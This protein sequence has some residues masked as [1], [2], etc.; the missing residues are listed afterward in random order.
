[1]LLPRPY[2]YD[3]GDAPDGLRYFVRVFCIALLPYAGIIRF[4]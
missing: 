1:M 3:L 4:K 2:Q